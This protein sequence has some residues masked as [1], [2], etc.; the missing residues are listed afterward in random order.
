MTLRKLTAATTG[1]V[2][3]V[4]L[5]WHT[6]A[7]AAEGDGYWLIQED[8]RIHAYGATTHHGDTG[9]GIPDPI[10][11]VVPSPSGEGYWLVAADG[12]V[13]AFDVPYFG[14]TGGRA[15]SAPMVGIAAPPPPTASEPSEPSESSEE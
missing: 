3:A 11:G 4:V 9:G 1:L 8:G 10:V 7:G 5:G 13:F 14:S 12:G 6:H 2:L 15:V